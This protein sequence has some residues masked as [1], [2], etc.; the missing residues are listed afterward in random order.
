MDE[1]RNTLTAWYK[2]E[3]R[4]LPWRDTRDPY[5][6]W[7]SEIILQQTRVQQGL[8]YYLRFISQFPDVLS[9][10]NAN[11]EEILRVWQ[12][13][14][15]YSRARNMHSAAKKIQLTHQGIFPSDYS[16]IRDF[17]GIG[18]YTAAAISSIAFNLPY[19]VVDGNVYRVISRILG[20]STPIDSSKGKKEFYKIAQLIL[21]PK[22]PGQSNQAIMEFGAIQC[23]PSSPLCESCPLSSKCFAFL[24]RCT[25]KLPVKNKKVKQRERFLNYLYIRTKGNF[26]LEKR[27]GN[28]IWKN[29]FQF[30]LIESVG[31][32]SPDEIIASSSWKSILS[33]NTF[34]IESISPI[35]IHLL[36]HQR[37]YLRF[38]TISTDDQIIN[39]NFVLVSHADKTKYA[40]PKPVENFLSES[41]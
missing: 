8:S 36:T 24:N 39:S 28:D 6:I 15:Y 19:A 14:G 11:E 38:F 13:L 5:K 29:L 35:K 7:V 17:K 25:D 2:R 9:L 4:E 3:M 1:Y 21:D 41:D 34:T 37:L 27:V 33:G 40:V 26:Y 12:G 23:L 10:A 22:N 16:S 18:D 20:I 31:L 30:P 32:V